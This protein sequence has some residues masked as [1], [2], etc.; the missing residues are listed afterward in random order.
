MTGLAT[1]PTIVRAA[2]PLCVAAIVTP[3]GTEPPWSDWLGCELVYQAL[4]GVMNNNGESGRPPL[5]GCGHRASF[6]TKLTAY[7]GVLAVLHARDRDGE[8][9]VV[10]VSVAETAASMTTA[11]LAYSY[12]GARESRSAGEHQLRCRDGWIGIWIYSQQ[13]RGFCD[14]LEAPHLFDDPRFARADDR[15]QN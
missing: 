4:S 13:W 6:A 15:Q 1:E 9:Q 11:P 8:G 5:Y 7:T 10:D 3:F 12:S 14:A 2:N